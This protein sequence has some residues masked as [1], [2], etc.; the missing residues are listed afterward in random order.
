VY[1][2]PTL[3]G[4]LKSFS[5]RESAYLPHTFSIIQAVVH[6]LS[7]D[8]QDIDPS[9]ACLYVSLLLIIT[10]SPNGRFVVLSNEKGHRVFVSS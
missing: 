4:W 1:P 2:G 10:G 5:S 3:G 9:N 8:Q 7:A 6:N